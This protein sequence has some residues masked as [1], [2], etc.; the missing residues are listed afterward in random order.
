MPKKQSATKIVRV[1]RWETPRSKR[2][3]KQDMWAQHLTLSPSRWL[4]ISKAKS[5]AE[6]LSSKAIRNL[7]MWEREIAQGS[8]GM[9]SADK[10]SR[11]FD[12]HPKGYTSRER[13]NCGNRLGLT[14]IASWLDY[15]ELPRPKS[16]Q[17]KR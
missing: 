16:H 10:Y 13:V 7:M 15:N 9:S 14:W 17:R 3:E 6:W 11:A 1:W 5:V 8:L 12:S 4:L 2:S